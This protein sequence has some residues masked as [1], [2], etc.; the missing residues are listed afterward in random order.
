M[1]CYLGLGKLLTEEG[2]VQ[3]HSSLLA[4]GTEEIHEWPAGSLLFVSPQTVLRAN[5]S[6]I[7]SPKRSLDRVHQADLLSTCAPAAASLDHAVAPEAEHHSVRHL[8]PT[9]AGVDRCQHVKQARAINAM[10]N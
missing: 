8:L 9:S 7:D 4:H 5:L 6:G 10:E 2:C 3:L 1:G